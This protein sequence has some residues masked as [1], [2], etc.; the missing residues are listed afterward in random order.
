MPRKN[1]R[2][3]RNFKKKRTFKKKR[4]NIHKP[5]V[6]RGPPVLP[7]RTFVMLKYFVEG[8]LLLSGASANT[9]S[10]RGNGAYDPE[11]GIGGHSPMGY[12]Q[13]AQLYQNYRV[14]K[15]AINF[16]ISSTT[17]PV[18]ISVTPSTTANIPPSTSIAREYPY[19]RYLTIA[20]TSQG[21]VSV[22]HAMMTKNV[23]GL[24]SIKYEDNCSSLVGGLPTDQWF[25][26]TNISSYNGGVSTT[27]CNIQLVYWME[28]FN[29][30][31]LTQSGLVGDHIFV[32]NEDTPFGQTGPTGPNSIFGGDTGPTLGY[33]ATGGHGA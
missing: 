26:T 8:K 5:L 21:C 15:S 11:F 29:R 10:F 4:V 30:V 33:G 17:V 7:D 1:F 23:F 24:K 22:K 18:N 28:F 3:K 9:I 20:G 13:W 31:E 14:H 25:W 27:S 32:N 2:R 6:I 12:D 16:T 19:N